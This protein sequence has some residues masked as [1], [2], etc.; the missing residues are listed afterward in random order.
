[1]EAE[2]VW[3]CGKPWLVVAGMYLLSAQQCFDPQWE[4]KQWTTEM[5]EEVARRLNAWADMKWGNDGIDA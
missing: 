1:M 5:L 4:S 3:K 2:V